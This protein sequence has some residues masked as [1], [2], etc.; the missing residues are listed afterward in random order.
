MS[1]VDDM[2]LSPAQCAAVTDARPQV[3]VAAAAGSGKTRLLVAAV[4]RALVD[5]RLPV[6]QLV[7]VTFTRKAGAELSSRVREALGACGRRDLA[8]ALDSAMVGT[9]DS[10]C[11][12]LVK[13]QALTI[14]LDP[15]CSV[16]EAEAA[17]LVKSEV[18]E[19]AWEFTVQQ[20]DQAALEVLCARGRRLCADVKALY[21]RLRSL[22]QQAPSL[23]MPAPSSE[24]E[25]RSRLVQ[26][27]QQALTAGAAQAKPSTTLTADLT[28]LRDCLNWL[29][30]P[31]EE[32]SGDTGLRTTAA[33]FPSR[34]SRVLAEHFDAVRSALHA[35]RCVLAEGVLSPLVDV[36]NTLLAEYHRVYSARK[37]EQGVIDFADLELKARDLLTGGLSGEPPACGLPGA[38][39]L[40]DEFQD[41]NEL[42]CTILSG[43][44]ATRVLMVG[45][46]RQSIY[47]FRGADVDVFKRRRAALACTDGEAGSGA[48]HR[49]DVNY[50][51]SQEIL[52]FVNG[53]FAQPGFFGDEFVCLAPDPDRAPICPDGASATGAGGH[54][55]S[56]NV[57]VLVAERGGDGVDGEAERTPWQQAEAEALAA[58]VRG[59][60]DREGWRQRDIVVLLPTQTQVEMYREALV[61][62][63]VR[64]YVV[65][66][67]GYYT[68]EEVADVV[69]LLRLILNPHDD[70]AL[71]TVLRSPLVGLSDDGLYLLGRAKRA[72]RARSIWEVARGAEVD[73]LDVA[74]QAA[75]ELLSARVA[76]IRPRIGRP[77]LARLI[78]DCISAFSYDL[79]LLAATDGRRRFANVR[80]LMRLAEEFESTTGPDL[81]AFVS[82]IRSTGQI[83]DR[84]GSAPTL[85]EGEDVVRLMTVHQAKGLEF[86][87]VVL[88]GLGADV[89]RP[90]PSTFVVGNDGRVGLFLK[91]Y[92]NRTYEANDPSWGPAVEIADDEL[93]REQE[94]DVR[95]LYV[96]M[97][98]AQERLVLVGA[99]PAKGL[100]G[101]Q[102]DRANSQ[103]L[104]A[105]GLSERRRDGGVVESVGDYRGG[106]AALS[107]DCLCASDIQDVTFPDVCGRR[108]DSA[109]AA[110]GEPG[111]PR[112]LELP[113]VAPAPTRVSYSSLAAYQ[114][115]PRRFYLER[116][117]GL[118]LE[119]RVLVFGE[120]ASGG[121]I[122][123]DAHELFDDSESHSGRDVG[124]LVHRLL[125]QLARDGRRPDTS[126][127]RESAE[128][129]LRRPRPANGRPRS[130]L[131]GT[132]H[133]GSV[134]LA[135]GR[136]P[137][138]R[139]G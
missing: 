10:L 108:A 90:E 1:S 77:G 80:K 66:G 115:C 54:A 112:L 34:K 136:A 7:A 87:V 117:L 49:L 27:L 106:D 32:R 29:E 9:I 109:K 17:E 23:T 21:D 73:D 131:R 39:L 33:L 121:T 61:E 25:V 135:D 86:P 123:R 130:R 119:G 65:R 38:L 82:V 57:E 128:R 41:T 55:S 116:V 113:T 44:G 76:Q 43:L 64:V 35:Y 22:G 91:G 124:I 110:P 69:A 26:A 60:V 67:K 15:A 3:L 134:G 20:A 127:V 138:A 59:L 45:D 4:V 132:P 13:D 89:H 51:S 71:V 37:A 19:R 92:R 62:R 16:L 102:P 94:E 78:D 8:L 83:G 72:R 74:D 126:I 105:D 63:D 139:F 46:E 100:P 36:V 70:L 11:R 52:A 98:R 58:Q 47:R 6:E 75:L 81:A 120:D 133:F 53:L 42:Q 40:V 103:G 104:G 68:Q 111:P 50:R 107:G 95:L 79:C 18:A 96:A 84:E 31:E 28:K 99:R 5:E 93:R 14:G 114:R 88:A 48:L 97:T 101:R 2:G 56:P 125:E 12:R 137:V 24:E 122:S 118:G 30:G 85:G 129:E